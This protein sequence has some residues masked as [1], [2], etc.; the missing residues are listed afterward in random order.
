MFGRLL[1]LKL[2][3]VIQYPL[4]GRLSASE[5]FLRG[6]N[7]RTVAA[8]LKIGELIEENDSAAGFTWFLR[9]TFCG[10]L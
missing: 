6:Q 2:W 9:L 7:L 3:S 10:I 4:Q 5:D 1:I 8:F